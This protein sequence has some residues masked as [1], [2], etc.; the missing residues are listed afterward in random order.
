[1]PG[2]VAAAFERLRG[3]SIE[4]LIREDLAMSS[5]PIAAEVLQGL[6]FSVRLVGE[7]AVDLSPDRLLLAAGATRSYRRTL[8]RVR[9]LPVG[10]R[11]VLLVWH[12]EPLPMPRAAG[13]RAQPLTVRELGKIV[14]RDRR[15]NDHYSNARFLRELARSGAVDALAVATKAYQAYLAE[16]GIEVF[17]VPLG[18][19]PSNGRLLHLERDVDVIFLGDFRLPRRRR[20]LRR[21]EREGI[22]VLTLGDYSNPALWGEGRVE[23]MNRVKIALNIPRLDGHLPDVRLVVAMANGALV[24]SEPLYLPEPYVPGVHYVE[25]PVERLAQ[26]IV[27]YLADEAARRRITEEAHRFVTTELTLERSFERL[28]ALAADGL[29]R[30]ATR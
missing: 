1:M 11:P 27:D 2:V 18:Y 3:Y 26:T 13:L 7:D 24:V 30:R 19:H 25:A 16:D 5:A 29:E 10:E 22:D 23:L 9:E 6:G 28:L 17:H 14:L 20:I 21:L 15:V 4:L 8:G 12:T